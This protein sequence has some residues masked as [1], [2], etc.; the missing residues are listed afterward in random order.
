MVGGLRR[1]VLVVLVG[2][3]GVVLVAVGLVATVRAVPVCVAAGVGGPGV[4]A[5]PSA[6]ARVEVVLVDLLLLLLLLLV[7]GSSAKVVAVVRLV[8]VGGLGGVC[9][10]G[11]SG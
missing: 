8:V 3:S 4:G 9:L 6:Q 5:L 2:R 10:V 11:G 1:W 7:A